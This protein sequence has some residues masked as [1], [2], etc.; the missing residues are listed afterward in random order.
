MVV[1][2]AEHHKEQAP[3]VTAEQH[4]EQASNVAGKHATALQSDNDHST[5]IMYRHTQQSS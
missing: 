4:K 3:H 1:V 5:H 2:T